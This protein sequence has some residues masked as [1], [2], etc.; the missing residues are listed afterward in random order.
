M[1]VGLALSA[2]EWTAHQV[3]QPAA[4]GS[5]E[6]LPGDGVEVRGGGIGIV[7][8]VDEL[9]FTALEVTG[10]FD[11][12]VRLDSFDGNRMFAGA[13]LMVREAADPGS[14]M[15]A[16]VA[17]PGGVGVVYYSRTGSGRAATYA[18]AGFSNPPDMWLRLQRRG[19]VLVGAISY[20]SNRWYEVGSS[21]FAST[22]PVLLGFSV[23]SWD[24]EILSRAR[25]ESFGPAT[26]LDR[27]RVGPG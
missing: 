7:G 26:G 2:A 15:G 22:D 10:D 14:A 12:Q 18:G 13:G 21:T 3:G 8:T 27:P 20:D 1:Q 24:G 17:T 19:E 4:L 11:Y 16:V 9:F 5:F 23:S 25:F 6:I